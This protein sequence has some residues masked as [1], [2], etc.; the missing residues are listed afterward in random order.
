MLTLLSL[1]LFLS[2]MAVQPQEPHLVQVTEGDNAVLQC[3][4]DPPEGPPENL[5]WYREAQTTP[6]LRLN[7]GLL[8]LRVQKGPQ[9]IWLII[10]NISEQMGGFYQCTGNASS[11]QA[12]RS[13][14]TVSV[15]GSGELFRWNISNLH[16]PRCDLG[17]GSSEGALPSSGHATSL[18]V[19]DKDQPV[20]VKTGP[21]CTPQR[22]SSNQ[23]QDLTVAPGSTLW[24]PCVMPQAS[25]TRSPIS[26]TRVH[27]KKSKLS[28]LSLTVGEDDTDMEKW[29]LVTVRGGAVLSLPQASARHTGTYHCN[30][31]NETIRMQLNVTAQS[32]VWH[33]LLKTG[34][35]KVPAVTLIYLIFCLGSLV[36]FLHLRKALI[37]RRKRKRMTDPARRFFK[38]TPPTGNGAQNQYGNVLS[39]STPSSATGRALRWAAGLGV[40]VPHYVQ[41]AGGAGSRSPPAAGPDEEGE[42]YEEPD[43]EEGSEFYENDS[44]LGPD[45]LSRDGSG[46]EHPEDE[47]QEPEYEDSFSNAADSYENED[48]SL[49][50]PVA[51]T[52]D[53]LSPPGPGW[54][55]SRE[56]TS[57]GSQSYEDMRGI[58]Y[59][60]PQLRSPWGQPGP[61]REEDADSYENMD[62]SDEPGPAWSGGGH[63][64]TWSTR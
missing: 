63:T 19:W 21:T 28:L 11:K 60:A 41:E 33:W 8:D 5:T 31:G 36:S 35:W 13:G 53:F 17:N 25:G 48:E 29:V 39:L 14:W 46:Y 43:S 40:A 18:Y 4:K 61:N 52:M 9:S 15:K 55:A 22:H 51:R 59:A 37:L 1:L 32:A 45:Q 30:F 57:L 3:L 44:N 62:N 58:L 34:G 26:W 23:S 2:P 7:Q 64:G 38:V 50:Q 27:P 47:A 10:S 42:A 56:A 16:D 20:P 12:W 49:S 54:D 6:F 24:L